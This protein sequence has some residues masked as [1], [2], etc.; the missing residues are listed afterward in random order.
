MLTLEYVKTIFELSIDET[1][2]YHKAEL[3]GFKFTL[4]EMRDM[5]LKEQLRSEQ[6]SS[7]GSSYSLI[8]IR[9]ASTRGRGGLRGRRGDIIPFKTPQ[10]D[11]SAP[12]AMSKQVKRKVFCGY[13]KKTGHSKEA[14]FRAAKLCFACGQVANQ[15][16]AHSSNPSN[17]IQTK[18]IKALLGTQ[19]TLRKSQVS[20]VSAQKIGT[21]KP[22]LLRMPLGQAKR[23]AQELRGP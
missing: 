2:T 1:L 16:A 20:A 19:G 12:S 13:C 23:M 18:F 17:V 10:T 22:K 3:H 7:S 11:Y 6:G 14:Y 21:P 15:I 5:L 4:S 9:I 8:R